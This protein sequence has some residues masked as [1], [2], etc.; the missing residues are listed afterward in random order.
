[1][2][3]KKDNDKSLPINSSKTGQ[4]IALLLAR[5]HEIVS[6]QTLIEELWGES[7]PRSAMTTLQ[8]YVYHARK[9][10]SRES[11]T[12]AGRDLLITRSPGYLIQ[13]EKH[14]VDAWVFEET[15]E[16]GRVH[17]RSGRPE[18]AADLFREALQLWRGPAFASIQPGSVLQAH[19]TY[20]AEL[21]IRATHLRLQAEQA[22]G[23]YEDIIPE[24]RSLVISH[25]LNESFHAQLIDALHRS[26]RRAE[27][28]HAYQDLRRVLDRELG[29]S[30]SPEVQLLQVALLDEGRRTD[31]GDRHAVGAR[32]L[33]QAPANL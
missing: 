2:E 20:L 12:T 21:R 6:T 9:L 19:A 24:L 26:G 16:R 4:V 8:T 7:P 29:I 27:A 11:V 22:M 15:L 1:M 10:F 14:E 33:R 3:I 32:P 13:L 5:R 23:Q 28:L 18:P 31:R 17:L 30:P 25:P